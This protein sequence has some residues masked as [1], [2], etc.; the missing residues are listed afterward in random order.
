MADEKTCR[1]ENTEARILDAAF[2]VVQ[3]RTIS[4]TRMAL[5]A[6]RAGLFQSNIHYYYKSKHELMLAV[7]RKVLAR[8]MELREA[9]L[10]QCGPDS[11]LAARIGVFWGQ[12]RAFI[13]EEPKYD[14]AEI[15]F[16]VQSR[17]DAE[18]KRTFVASFAAWRAEIAKMLT[19]FGMPDERAAM[20][21]AVMTSMME[22]A[23][24]QYLI[25][26]TAFDL[27]D[28]FDYCT[29]MVIREISAG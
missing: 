10:A 21:A 1:E 29:Q 5:I 9:L 20:L 13:L 27:D 11:D 14:L 8:C 15:D 18:V 17:V 16:W 2:D 3:E 4:G 23:S 12:K 19:E 28:Y 6:E 26:P 24:F 7:Q 22:G 25:D